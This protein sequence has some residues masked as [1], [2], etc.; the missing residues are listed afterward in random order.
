MFDAHPPFQIDGN[1]GFTAGI[2]E[3]LIQSHDGFIFV[4]P[5][6]PDSWK[7]G[8]IEG[9]RARGGF[10]IEKLEWKDSKIATL[11][12][13]SNLGGNCRIRSYSLLK[14]EDSVTL[15]QAK[16]EHSNP[17]YRVPQI[18]Q[19]IVSSKVKVEITI[20]VNTYLCDFKTEPGN[21]YTFSG[22]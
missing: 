5:A 13:K 9:L 20:F 22:M 8:S 1:F 19:P 17:F 10:E 15:N 2:A 7:S 18:K 6:L 12:I 3:M 14:S 21:E 11:V 4:L 16:G